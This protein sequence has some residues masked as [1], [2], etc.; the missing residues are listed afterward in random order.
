MSKPTRNA[1][2]RLVISVLPLLLAACTQP[3]TNSTGS[4]SACPEPARM[5]RVSSSL[6]APVSPE[7]YL[8]RAQNDIAQ[9]QQTL[10]DS[11]TR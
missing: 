3:S 2:S 8:D 9:W 7:S 6:M 4:S 1:S 11:A 10:T 5:P